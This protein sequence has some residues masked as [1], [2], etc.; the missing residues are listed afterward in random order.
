MT[1]VR[2]VH[3]QGYAYQYHPW[4]TGVCLRP[5][6]GSPC[7]CAGR[8]HIHERWIPMSLL[9]LMRANSN[10]QALALTPPW[11]F[12][13]QAHWHSCVR[14][15][16]W[17]SHAS[18]PLHMCC[19]S[20]IGWQLRVRTPAHL[21]RRSWPWLAT[22]NHSRVF[23]KFSSCS[24]AVPRTGGTCPWQKGVPGRLLGGRVGS[25]TYWPQGEVSCS[26][27]RRRSGIPPHLKLWYWHII[28]ESAI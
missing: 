5:I 19:Q 22:S 7:P 13:Y 3:G 14:A 21:C 25:V 17:V 4:G 26:G 1:C 20:V 11:G 6:D 9:M 12:N 16:A 23:H 28:Q 15:H 27:A 10:Y 8:V 24:C 18:L 2:E